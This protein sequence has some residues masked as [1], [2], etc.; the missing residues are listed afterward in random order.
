M[1]YASEL[2]DDRRKL[3]IRYHDGR[4]VTLH[5]ERPEGFTDSQALRAGNEF[6]RADRLVAGQVNRTRRVRIGRHA[7]LVKLNTGPP[8]WWLPRVEI[9]PN[10]AM[11]GWLQ[12]LIAASWRRER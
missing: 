4:T 9:G 2:S 12:V 8:T 10:K 7:V 1:S 11:L 3:R 5:S 6:Q